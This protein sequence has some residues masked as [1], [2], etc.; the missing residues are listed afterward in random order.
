ME[1]L[2]DYTNPL[3]DSYRSFTHDAIMIH[4]FIP[5]KAEAGLLKARFTI[6][7]GIR[8]FHKR[9]HAKKS[10]SWFYFW[11][12]WGEWSGS[13]STTCGTG[14]ET[15]PRTCSYDTAKNTEPLTDEK[16]CNLK[17]CWSAW[18]AWDD[19]NIE[20]GLKGRVSDL[21]YLVAVRVSLT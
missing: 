1:T 18:G 21:K 14:V 7:D 11:S 4:G 2:V 8:Y 9:Q 13:C 5:E 20:T 15:R 10:I 3:L 17:G 16:S 19:C 12:Q 6:S